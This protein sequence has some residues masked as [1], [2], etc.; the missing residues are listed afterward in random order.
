MWLRMF[1]VMALAVAL[2]ACS[3][4][5][6]VSPEVEAALDAA[7]SDEMTASLR[8]LSGSIAGLRQRMEQAFP[9][10]TALIEGGGGTEKRLLEELSAGAADANDDG[11]IDIADPIYVLSWL[12]GAEDPPRPPFPDP[13]PDPSA[14]GLD[15]ADYPPGE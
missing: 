12:F 7:E 10:V 3:G 13:G 5:D 6:G 4:S 15:C 14:D 8:G 1:V 2:G 11:E 9:E